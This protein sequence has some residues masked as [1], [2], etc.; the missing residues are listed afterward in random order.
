MLNTNFASHP[1]EW[2]LKMLTKAAAKDLRVKG[3]MRV[4]SDCS[5]PTILIYSGH[6][7]IFDAW[8][9]KPL[10]CCCPANWRWT[11][12]YTDIISW[13]NKILVKQFLND[14]R[15]NDINKIL[16]SSYC[17]CDQHIAM[18][19]ARHKIHW[20]THFHCHT[21]NHLIQLGDIRLV[22]GW[23][24]QWNQCH[25]GVN[26]CVPWI[27]TI[28]FWRLFCTSFYIHCTW[29]QCTTSQG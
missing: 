22:I 15:S 9:A 23:V 2:H 27:V 13:E 16:H 17:S 4:V 12:E 19:S 7:L 29:G 24:L 26:I 20:H 28:L 1:C 6:F 18:T 10:V 3:V 8:G 11:Q 5:K 25:N 14:L 21:M